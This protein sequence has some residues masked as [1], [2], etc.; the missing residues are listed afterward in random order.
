MEK[1]HSVKTGSF[2]LLVPKIYFLPKLTYCT[3][4]PKDWVTVDTFNI[5]LLMPAGCTEE[6]YH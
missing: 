6:A 1:S 2:S 3:A 4:N 5:N